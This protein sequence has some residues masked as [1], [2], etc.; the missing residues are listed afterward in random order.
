MIWKPKRIG[1]KESWTFSQ[2]SNSALN[3]FIQL[4]MTVYFSGF[5]SLVSFLSLKKNS[6]ETK[7]VE[8]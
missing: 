1:A 7:V 6:V 8:L 5:F 4:E 2:Y 3:A